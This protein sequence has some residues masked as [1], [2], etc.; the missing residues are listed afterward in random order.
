MKQQVRGHFSVRYT[1]GREEKIFPKDKKHKIK[2]ETD[3]RAAQKLG[4]VDRYTYEGKSK[5]DF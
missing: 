2:I 4:A 3:L 5:W 1:S